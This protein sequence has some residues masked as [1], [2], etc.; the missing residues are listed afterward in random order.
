MHIKLRISSA[1]RLINDVNDGYYNNFRF[2]IFLKIKL[3]FGLWR[4]VCVCVNVYLHGYCHTVGGAL[5]AFCTAA[6]FETPIVT[7]AAAAAAASDANGI[8]VEFVPA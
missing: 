3:W 7:A 6:A 2:G 8:M 1:S 4:S 5:A